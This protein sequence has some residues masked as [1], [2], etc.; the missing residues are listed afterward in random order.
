MAFVGRYE[1][2]SAPAGLRAG[3]DQPDRRP[4]RE[5]ARRGPGAGREDRPN[6]PAA[7][8]ATKRA[9]W[10]ALELGLT[11]ACRA[12]ARRARVDVG[13][14]RPGRGPARVRREARAAVAGAEREAP[15]STVNLGRPAVRADEPAGRRRRRP[16]VHVGERAWSRAELRDRADAVAADLAAAGVGPGHAVG[17]MLPNGA[18]LVATLFGVWR[19]GGGLRAAEPAPDRRRGRPRAD[20]AGPGRR[21]PPFRPPDRR[22]PG[23]PTLGRD[24]DRAPFGRPTPR[25]CQFTSGTTGRPKPVAA[26]PRRRAHAARRRGGQAP[27]D[28]ASGPAADRGPDA[29]PRARC[30]CRCGPAST[31]CCS[32]SGSARRSCVMDA[33]RHRRASPG[34]SRRF[35]IRSTVLPPAAMTDAGRRPAGHRPGAAALRAQ[36]HRAAVAAPGPAVPRPVRHRGAQQL[37][38]D[39]DRRRDRRLDRRRLAGARRDQARLGRPSPRRGRAADRPTAPGELRGAHAGA[40]RRATPTAA[41]SPTG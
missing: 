23:R 18:E 19:A 2:M 37:R 30:R 22:S 24:D 6:S 7:M 34:S 15:A 3:H 12:G 21:P 4:A 1:R 41:T 25:S 39:R 26:A 8:A 31:T 14:P 17:V 38:P 33:L 5:A 11:D 13:P 16:L 35:G 36:H 27:G 28:R 29:Q 32:P 10:G 20:V 40:E 9:L